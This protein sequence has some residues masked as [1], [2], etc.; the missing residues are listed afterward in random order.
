MSGLGDL[1]WAQKSRRCPQV[2]GSRGAAGSAAAA[3]GPHR[4]VATLRTSFWD[5]PSDVCPAYVIHRLSA[6]SRKSARSDL[7]PRGDLCNLKSRTSIHS[8]AVVAAELYQ[9]G[10]NFEWDC[11]R[12][13]LHLTL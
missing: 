10:V 8:G 3:G 9:D 13:Q 7:V 11:S 4:A 5:L 6:T 1:N 2:R 12:R